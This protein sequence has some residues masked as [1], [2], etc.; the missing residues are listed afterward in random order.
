MRLALASQNQHLLHQYIIPDVDPPQQQQQHSGKKEWLPPPPFSQFS[1]CSPSPSSPSRPPARPSQARSAPPRSSPSRTPSATQAT[2][3]ARAW[4]AATPSPP[5]RAGT[6]TA[7]P[8]AGPRDATATAS[9]SPT[10]SSPISASRTWPSPASPTTAASS[11]AST[12]ATPAPPSSRS[13]ATSPHILSTQVQNFLRHQKSTI[14]RYGRQTSQQWYESALVYVEIGGDDINFGLAQGGNYVVQVVVPAVVKGLADA[15][16]TLYS[17]GARNVL[18]FNMPRADCAPTYLQ[19]FGEYQPGTYHLDKDGCI[20][21]VGELVS[22]FNSAMQTMA[23]EL[24]QNYTGLNV[25]YFDWNAANTEVIENM[26]TYGF[27]TNLKSCC[28]GG[29]QYNCNGGGLCGCG[30]ANVSYTVCKDPD[31]YTTFDGVHYTGHFYRIMTD[32][33]LAGQY[34][35]P[36]VTLQKGCKVI[37]E[38]P[39]GPL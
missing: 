8:T 22:V 16:A 31:E 10:C 38:E 23:G 30:T 24:R 28:G 15:I 36:N 37:P 2:A 11:S 13:R 17:A 25:Y 27:T 4:A 1:R 18:L 32:F 6:P 19:A 5:S 20:V 7:S 35:S 3:T 26:D 33:I 39:A 14:A 29:G 9:S 34:I 21:E 12:L